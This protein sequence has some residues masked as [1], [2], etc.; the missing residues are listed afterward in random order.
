MV[1]THKP[2][3]F[4]GTNMMHRFDGRTGLFQTETAACQNFLIGTGMQIGKSAGELDLPAIHS[5]GA[6]GTHPFSNRISR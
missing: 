1:I 2:Q 6:I 4:G 5:D 3:W